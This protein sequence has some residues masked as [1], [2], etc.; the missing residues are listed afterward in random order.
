[1]DKVINQNIKTTRL[2]FIVTVFLIGLWLYALFQLYNLSALYKD[3]I[4][5]GE[6]MLSIKNPPATTI[7]YA[8]LQSKADKINLLRIISIVILI[9]L[10]II[11]ITRTIRTVIRDRKASHLTS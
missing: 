3:Q 7:D 11:T 5:M 6:F 9:G 4:E 10:P 2:K 8:K 1:M